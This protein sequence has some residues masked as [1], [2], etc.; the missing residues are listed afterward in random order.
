MNNRPV[1]KWSI[2]ECFHELFDLKELMDFIAAKFTF[3]E[4]HN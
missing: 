3:I 4:C 1:H 2:L